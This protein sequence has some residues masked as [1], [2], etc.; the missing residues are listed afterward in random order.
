MAPPSAVVNLM[1]QTFKAIPPKD[2]VADF[3]K[4]QDEKPAP[5]AR[6]I[7]GKVWA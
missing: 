5:N 1:Q 2:I 4:V 6:R 3:V 7:C